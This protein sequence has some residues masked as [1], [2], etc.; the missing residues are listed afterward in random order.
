M[1]VMRSQDMSG[2]TSCTDMWQHGTRHVQTCGKKA[3]KRRRVAV[4]CSFLCVVRRLDSTRHHSC[5]CA[6]ISLTH[7]NTESTGAPTRRPTQTHTFTYI[8]IHTYTHIHTHTH[9]HVQSCTHTHT[10]VLPPQYVLLHTATAHNVLL[11]TTN[12]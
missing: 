12:A 8:H 5:V 3:T 11:T 10:R 2:D 1:R 6:K 4:C 9:T 7:C